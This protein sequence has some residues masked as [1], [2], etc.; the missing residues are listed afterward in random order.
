M[1]L[2]YENTGEKSM[3]TDLKTNYDVVMN[4]VDVEK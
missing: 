4:T 3:T 2:N 1:T